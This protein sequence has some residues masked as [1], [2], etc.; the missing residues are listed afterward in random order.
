MTTIFDAHLFAA[1][2][3][4]RRGDL[5]LRDAAAATGVSAATLSRLENGETPDMETFLV[6]TTW[7]GW[8]VAAFLRP[9]DQAR[10]TVQLIDQ[11][12]RKDGVLAVKVIEAFL[13]LLQTVR[14]RDTQ[15][16]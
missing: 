12:L 8:P 3:R 5:G 15:G 16:M 11:A 2:V 13:V 9:A 14:G 1:A 10:D 4:A 7:T 6:L